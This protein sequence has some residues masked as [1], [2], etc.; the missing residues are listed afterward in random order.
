MGIKNDMAWF[1]WTEEKR[2]MPVWIGIK[3]IVF[4][5]IRKSLLLQEKIFKLRLLRL[6]AIVVSNV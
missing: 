5:G 3:R 1:M 4:T 6:C 2:K